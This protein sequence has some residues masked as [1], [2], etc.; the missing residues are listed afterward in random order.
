MR[1]AG[2]QDFCRRGVCR[3][4]GQ[5]SEESSLCELKLQTN[6]VKNYHNNGAKTVEK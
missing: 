2:V 6:I 3:L 4:G 5:G 1:L